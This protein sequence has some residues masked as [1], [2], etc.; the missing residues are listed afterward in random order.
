MNN[1]TIAILGVLLV[2]QLAA[3]VALQWE[4][5]DLNAGQ[6]EA[7][8]LDFAANDVDHIRIS[9]HEGASVELRRQD[10]AWRLTA[11]A[12]FPADQAT[13]E[14]LLG[15]L[16][17]MKQGWPVATTPAAARR[18]KVAEDDYERHIVLARGDQTLAEIYVG[19]SPGLRK[20]HVRRPD[21]Q[22][23]YAVAFNTFDAPVKTTGW[24]D[25]R[26]AQ[27]D[28]Q[29]L[30]RIELPALTLLRE[31]GGWR[32]A[33]LAEGE[34][35]VA[36]EVDNLVGQVSTVTISDVLQKAP[37]SPGEP[38]LVYTLHTR[39]GDKREYRFYKSPDKGQGYILKTSMRKEY[40]K[41][42]AFYVD[43]IKSASRDRLVKAKDGKG[44]ATGGETQSIMP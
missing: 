9:D 40:F 3:A 39:S 23:I 41:V 5:R 6:D 26:I 4:G 21:Q 44:A 32:L 43:S 37:A 15:K 35:M 33:D 1:R 12:G 20:V 34:E 31:N 36:E 8:L 11:L 27:L 2:L 42:P 38:T 18:F 17:A 19:T 28:R 13:V 14:R 24:I 25:K 7:A 16:A 29:K 30:Q 22:A 10:G